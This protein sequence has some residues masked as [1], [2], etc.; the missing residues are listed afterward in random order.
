MV[1]NIKELS[2]PAHI[3][4]AL[5]GDLSAVNSISIDAP[6]KA[7]EALTRAPISIAL[8]S[9]ID[10]MQPHEIECI[11]LSELTSYEILE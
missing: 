1:L 2:L 5:R 8:T 9:N 11:E 6:L 10:D 4:Q 7:R 3:L